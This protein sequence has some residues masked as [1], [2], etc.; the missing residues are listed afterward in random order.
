MAGVEDME[1]EYRETSYADLEE[2]MYRARLV[3]VEPCTTQFGNQLRWIF[4]VYDEE[5]VVEVSGITSTKFSSRSKGFAWYSALGGKV[6]DGKI[7]IKDV[8]GNEALVEIKQ[9]VGRDGTTKFSNIV[10]VKP[11]P[12]KK[13]KKKSDEEEE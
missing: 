10:D 5:E 2:G 7:R 4:E 3:R 11:L 9:R 12:K 13:K 1:F 6:T 8:I